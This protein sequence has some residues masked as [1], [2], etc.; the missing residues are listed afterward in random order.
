MAGFGRERTGRFRSAQWEN[1]PLAAFLVS[2]A[3]FIEAA[4]CFEQ[5]FDVVSAQRMRPK[6]PSK[7]S[8]IL[9]SAVRAISLLSTIP[10]LL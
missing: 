1:P 10:G 5:A 9:N 7:P 6:V 4:R 2:V 3:C 8:F